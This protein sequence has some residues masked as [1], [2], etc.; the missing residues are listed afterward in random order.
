MKSIR[1]FFLLSIFSAALV[2]EAAPEL[3]QANESKNISQ[4]IRSNAPHY[5]S[6]MKNKVNAADL[7]SFTKY[8]G[9]VAGDP[10]MGNFA[11]IPL[12][13]KDGTRRMRFVN[14]DFDDAGVG[15]FAVDFA[16]YVITVEATFSKVKK[17]DLE[18]A[19]IKGLRGQK[20]LAPKEVQKFL[21]MPLKEYDKLSAAYVRKHSNAKGFILEEGKVEADNRQIPRSAIA[22]LFPNM[23]L[24]DIAI[25]PRERGGSEGVRVWTLVEEA[26]GERHIIELKPLETSGLS[27]YKEQPPLTEWLKDVYETFW[28]G[29]QTSDYDIVEIKGV[30]QFWKRPKKYSLIDD[31]KDKFETANELAIYDANL[32]GLAHSQ[33][34]QS[35]AYLNAIEYDPKGFHKAI[36]NM[37]DDYLSFAKKSY[38]ELK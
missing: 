8:E 20:V 11:P 30:G 33:Q 1:Y 36:E 23:K 3:R 19:Y 14:I 35:A 18:E 27:E 38:E 24:I 22:N 4:F 31:L 17:K 25:R 16:R 13:S 37:V 26:N 21:D 32:L 9:F 15:P 5:W 7:K 2:A 28:P 29:L 12:R 6:Y 10:H 34:Q